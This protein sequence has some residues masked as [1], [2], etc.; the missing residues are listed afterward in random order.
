[1]LSATLPRGGPPPPGDDEPIDDGG[2]DGK[3]RRNRREDNL[4]PNVKAH[5]LVSYLTRHQTGVKVKEICEQFNVGR[6]EHC[7]LFSSRFCQ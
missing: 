2:G 3:K 4:K 5:I 7:S 6:L 1:M